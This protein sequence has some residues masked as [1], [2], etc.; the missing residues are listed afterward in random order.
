MSASDIVSESVKTVLGQAGIRE[1]KIEERDF[2]GEHWVVVYVEQG[3]V[4]AGQSLAG[5]IERKIQESRSNPDIAVTVFF[6]AQER[7]VEEAAAATSGGKLSGRAVDQLIQLL[8][9]RSRTSEAVPSL[10]YMEDP[11][12]SLSAV[13]ASRHHVIYGRRG[14]GKTALLLEVKRLVQER[15]N[16]ATWINAHVIRHESPETAFAVLAES[17]VETIIHRLGTSA[18][19]SA[20]ALENLRASFSHDP[21]LAAAKIPEFN[22][23]LRNVLRADIL[24]LFVFIDDFYLLTTEFQPKLLDLLA[25][26]LRD[27]DAWIKVASI[28]RL[29]KTFDV[30]SRRGLEIPHDAS[31]VD[32]DVTLENPIAAQKFL[33][34]MLNSYTATA[35][36]KDVASI[37]KPQA[38]GR[39]VLASG[40]VPRDYINL[41]S[42]SILVAREA[43][44]QAAEIG[45][46]DVAVA[47]GKYAQSKKRDLE[48]DVDAI[49]STGL[50]AS[51]S[52][53]SGQVKGGKSTYFRVPMSGKSDG[54]YEILARLVDLRFAHLVQSSLSDQHRAGVKYEA[55]IL[56]LSEYTDIRLHRGLNNLDIEDGRW[57]WRMTGRAGT[58]KKLGGTELR[59][60]LRQAPLLELSQLEESGGLSGAG[61]Q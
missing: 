52:N 53:M 42:D 35:G 10:R 60:I 39:L 46:E 31:K 13:A 25:G 15:G 45:K 51:L 14:V 21:E 59:D 16:A 30:S 54:G 38:L 17:I 48:Q 8:E 57:V 32:L 29:T 33:E 43:R 61:A 12:A 41:F 36:I 18:S 50:L 4:A 23:A 27:C 6:R 24:Q 44:S 9:A 11:R 40:G 20:V 1:S 34:S 56:A 5:E 49:E 3:S 37:S 2:P 47:A 55:Y 22:R 7:S 26:A 19:T 28:E 58:A